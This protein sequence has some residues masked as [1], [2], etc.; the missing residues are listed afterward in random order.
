MKRFLSRKGTLTST[1]LLALGV[2]SFTISSAVAGGDIGG[3]CCADLEERVAE[4]EATTVRKG[5]RKVSLTLYGQVN[6]GIMHWDD[7]EVKDSFVVDNINSSSRFGFYGSAKIRPGW[8]AG[9]R[10]EM[11]FDDDESSVVTNT[12]NDDGNGENG[13]LDLRKSFWWIKSDRYGTLSLG[14]RYHASG[15]TKAADLSGTRVIATAAVSYVGGG[16]FFRNTAGAATGINFGTV[17]TDLVLTRGDVV[18]Y[19]S[20]TL[21]GFTVSTS[22]GEDD[23]G[24]V[25]LYY[26][27]KHRNYEI[28]AAVGYADSTDGAAEWDQWTGSFGIKHVPTGLNIHVAGGDR[29]T[30]GNAFD[31]QFFYAKAGITRKW[32]S[33][34]DTSISFDYYYG[35]EIASAN[36][37]S[38]HWGVQFVQNI[39]AA[40]MELYSMYS[41]NEYD[42]ANANY[43]DID[44]FMSGARIKF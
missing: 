19:D 31:E 40:A 42:D 13:L 17:A 6:K 30:T 15:D 36:S 11:E 12:G 5:N 24:D 10:V 18:R 9:Y 29:S 25:A 26:S 1:L 22:W 21:A 14:Q 43:Q 23:I 3:N 33:H 28:A 7:G 8:S 4:L 32:N 39:D 16:F 35:D 34:G 2:S 38:R 44:I 37:H 41:H 20:P 27:G